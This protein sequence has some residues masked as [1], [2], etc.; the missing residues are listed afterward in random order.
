MIVEEVL[1]LNIRGNVKFD[2]FIAKQL[3]KAGF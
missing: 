3:Q 2:I 1:K